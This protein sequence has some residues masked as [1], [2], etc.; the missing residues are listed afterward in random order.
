MEEIH[1]LV[2]DEG[3]SKNAIAFHVP[4]ENLMSPQPDSDPVKVL[5]KPPATPTRLDQKKEIDPKRSKRN[6][7]CLGQGCRTRSA[8][9][10]RD[11]KSEMRD[12]YWSMLVRNFTRMIEDVFQTCEKTDSVPH[13]Q[14][15]VL[16]LENSLRDFKNLV[17]WMELKW[18]Y[19]N[20]PVK[21]RPKSLAWEVRKSSPC[22]INRSPSENY[23]TPEEMKKFESFS[24]TKTPNRNLNFNSSEFENA[25]K[26]I[27]AAEN[28]KDK[29][30]VAKEDGPPEPSISEN[31]SVV[32]GDATF[33]SVSSQTDLEDEAATVSEEFEVTPI[34]MEG[35]CQ[36]DEIDLESLGPLE[37]TKE[38][39]KLK[40]PPRPALVKP[41][42]ASSLSQRVPSKPAGRGRAMPVT[43]TAPQLRTARSISD[44]RSNALSYPIR[45]Q[46]KRPV[47]LKPFPTS[48][49]AVRTNP[50][51]LGITTAST[52]P[53]K[54]NLGLVRGV[55]SKLSDIDQKFVGRQNQEFEH[56]ELAE[57]SN[58]SSSINSSSSRSSWADKVKGPLSAL[59]TTTEVRSVED[60]LLKSK[61]ATSPED[62]G[63]KMV[64]TRSRLK[65]SPAGKVDNLRRSATIIK[66]SQD[67]NSKSNLFPKNRFNQP[68]S[69]RSLPSLSLN[70][71]E[72]SEPA[73]KKPISRAQLTKPERK[74]APSVTKQAAKPKSSEMKS[75]KNTAN[76]RISKESP[77]EKPEDK[78][79]EE[80]VEM[81]E[82]VL[83]MP[84]ANLLNGK[85]SPVMSE[86]EASPEH[87]AKSEKGD[88]DREEEEKLNRE[89]EE[90]NQEEARLER[91]IKELQTEYDDME[92]KPVDSHS[93]E[94]DVE[95]TDWYELCERE[96][97]SESLQAL[98]EVKDLASHPERIID[99]HQK[100][101]SPS[102]RKINNEKTFLEK[103]ESAHE[104]RQKFLEEYKK[105]IHELDKKIQEVQVAKELNNTLKR[106]K[107]QQKLKR[108]DEIRNRLLEEKKRKAHDEEEKGKEIA[109]I[110]SLEAQ[111]KRHDYFVQKQE[112]EDRLQGI[113]EERQRRQE[114]KAA[115]KAA[116]EERKKNLDAERLAKAEKIM[117]KWRVTEERID[118]EQQEKE[119]ERLEQAREKARDR[120]ERQKAR[121]ATQRATQEE[122]KIKIQ[123]K[124]EESANRREENLEQIKQRA[125][126]C[127]FFRTDVAPRLAPYETH[128][129]CTLCNV[130][131]GSDVYLVSH[132]RGR[133]HQ[134][135]VK[136]QL[137]GKDVSREELEVF[138]LKHIEEAPANSTDTKLELDKERQRALKKKFKK[139]RLRM[140]AKGQEFES[141]RVASAIP[142][143]PSKSRIQ[144]CLKDIER[145]FNAQG[146]GLWSDPAITSL[147]RALSEICRIFEKKIP[148]DKLV[149][150]NLGGI[151]F[152]SDLLALAM[153]SSAGSPLFIPIKCFMTLCN[154][155]TLGCTNS[156]NNCR[157]VVLSNKIS[158][159]MDLLLHR[160]TNT[161]PQKPRSGSSLAICTD[162]FA[163]S[164]MNLL[165]MILEQAVPGAVNQ[166][167]D[168]FVPRLQD[169]VS[170]AVCMGLL[171]KLAACCSS[172]RDPIDDDP[173]SA[174]FLLST[175]RLL[176]SLVA[177][178][179]TGGS[180]AIRQDVSQ[181]GATLRITE[182]MGGVS[183]LY[184][185]L[186]HQGA[187]PRTGSAPPPP[188]PAH[189]VSVA[190]ETLR[191]L[192][193]VA[194]MDLNLFQ[195]VLGAEGMSLQFRHLAS[196]LLWACSN[197]ETQE[198]E[199]L[200]QGV[201][202][203]VGF[204][205]VRNHDNQTTIQ[206][207]FTPTVLQQLCNLPIQYF[208]EERLS[209]VLLPTLLACCW[210]NAET[211]AVLEQEVGFEMLQSFKVSE[212]GQKD[213]I[214][215]LLDSLDPSKVESKSNKT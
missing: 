32:I 66:S 101:S 60:L 144:K 62:E 125:L 90:L 103:Q 207:G 202:R 136:M 201:I 67:L 22:T 25:L 115:K 88:S 192:Q 1:L 27:R 29:Q 153:E 63:W 48:A 85:V 188:L 105:K 96:N 111:N 78:K 14:S 77:S 186:L 154:A 146:K 13:C 123:A 121:E 200:L 118:R 44:S 50:S 73:S 33:P 209:A 106:D 97:Q 210:E 172:V 18:K 215:I 196:Y 99:L 199:E 86:C 12:V 46:V 204:F 57:R 179:R 59:A 53:S 122:L 134:Q 160:L 195:G 190:V 10:G 87:A 120:E 34:K 175:L 124:Q 80:N 162:N 81:S 184:G 70:L 117:E 15:I 208:S 137:G 149:F 163:G 132:L 161:I 21:E 41:T 55:R 116:A 107:I 206:S 28:E 148:S 151:N 173:S 64:K 145:L 214:V 110:V 182:L 43:P 167:D 71:G 176:R 58:S 158:A 42:V 130:W 198:Y 45:T 19:E 54:P 203:I 178:A 128:K 168:Q 189:T 165:G 61:D 147:E 20:T 69:A 40:V 92:S 39:E 193:E 113:H 152:L 95:I 108:A 133:Q 74:T 76:P 16:I 31:S 6:S 213:S 112:E 143:S 205:A 150:L 114:E 104:K 3:L 164:L 166:S 7:E 49:P 35:S 131:I 140:I 83:L 37:T 9:A 11:K 26:E 36:T 138:S 4:V 47:D 126:E 212:A 177:C 79:K 155:F 8:S 127:C 98:D 51:R 91:E 170:Y 24:K 159:I 93:N 30:E 157:Y 23:W 68:S 119:K 197:V 187:P 142:D 75:P 135:A 181:L 171:E 174:A 102:R 180:G 129:L 38:E 100:L 84:E 185:M 17:S 56:P 89:T 139:I 94:D 5:K 2:Q 72:K 141:S 194:E 191:L 65:I 82:A 156:E 183:M 211:R 169:V 52:L 109:F